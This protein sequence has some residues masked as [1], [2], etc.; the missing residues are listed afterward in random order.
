MSEPT[1]LFSARLTPHRS[2][3]PQG[4]RIL[5]GFV[6]TFCVTVG[7]VFLSVGLWPVTGFMGLDLL[8]IYMAFR[9]SYRDGETYEDIEVSRQHVSLAHV[10]PKGGRRE[11]AFPQFGTRFEVDRHEEI[12]ITAMRIANRQETVAFGKFLNPADRESF[13]VEFSQALSSAKR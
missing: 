2:L 3:S 5:M 11:F 13:A 9:A 10:T 1:P 7:L 4:F 12:G 6:A 8:L